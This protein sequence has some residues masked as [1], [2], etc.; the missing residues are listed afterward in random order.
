MIVLDLPMPL[1][2]NRTRK[3]D[4]AALPRIQAWVRSAHNLVMSQGRLPK[5][6]HGPY[7]LTV[8]LP[9]G[10]PIDPDNTLKMPIDYLR[11]LELIDND[12][13]RLMRKLT[14]EI[15]EAPE[16]CRVVVEAV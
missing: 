10:C 13:A 4:R 2:V 12:N 8:I 16:G 15:G 5:A 9:E 1:S 3:L 14:A 11:T 7:R 6:I